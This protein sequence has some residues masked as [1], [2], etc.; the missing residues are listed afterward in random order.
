MFNA[1]AMFEGLRLVVFDG[2]LACV[3]LLINVPWNRKIPLNL[4]G[5]FA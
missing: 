1:L 3:H 5:T 4:H 2:E